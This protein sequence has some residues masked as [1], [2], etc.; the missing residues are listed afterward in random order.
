[1]DL[2]L[3]NNYHGNLLNKIQNEYPIIEK[4]TENFN[5]SQSQFMDNMLT[6]SQLT[7]LRAARQC[8]AEI[9]KVKLA[10]EEAFF[11]IK[12]NEIKIKK[13]ELKKGT[14]F[15]NDFK[16]ELIEIEIAE[17]KT[18]NA[19]IIDNVNGAVRK[20]SNFMAQY[21]NILNP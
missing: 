1:M 12:K 3:L 16:K 11:K 18:Q 19:N 21:K 17:L 2:Q 13:K 20:M 4:A 10:I 6:I 5:K 15:S 7:P 9:K 8:V 14:L